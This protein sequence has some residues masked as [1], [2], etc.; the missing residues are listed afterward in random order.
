MVFCLSS[1]SRNKGFF[2]RRSPHCTRIPFF[3][4]LLYKCIQLFLSLVESILSSTN[5]LRWISSP[6]LSTSLLWG[7]GEFD[8]WIYR[9]PHSVSPRPA[10]CEHWTHAHGIFPF[11]YGGFRLLQW[12]RAPACCVG[13]WN[14]ASVSTP[15]FSKSVAAAARDFPHI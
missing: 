7:E 1:V 14:C 2:P 15:W 10:E 13:L 4:S 9:L 12:V 6:L 8:A 11:S 3:A 5:F